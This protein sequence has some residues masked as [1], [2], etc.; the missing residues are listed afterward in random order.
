MNKTF[1]PYCGSDDIDRNY[2]YD[3]A[4][5]EYECRFCGES[6]MDSELVYCEKCGWVPIPESELPNEECVQ[7]DL[8]AEADADK[9]QQAQE[10]ELQRER[11]R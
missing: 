11:K 5:T 3:T 4:N 6:F 2:N 1:C 7:L 9:K 10:Q 8:F